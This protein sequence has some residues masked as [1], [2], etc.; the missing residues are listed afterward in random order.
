MK[1]I[2]I[3]QEQSIKTIKKYILEN[4]DKDEISDIARDITG[5]HSGL[6]Y[7]RETSK[8]YDKFENELHDIMAYT[9]EQIGEDGLPDYVVKNSQGLD[10]FKNSVVW[11]CFEVL[12][13]EISNA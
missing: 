10:Q 9:Q 3:N 11:F 4:W 2:Y 7:Y 12:C 13:Q 1:T 5:G 6:I 8:L